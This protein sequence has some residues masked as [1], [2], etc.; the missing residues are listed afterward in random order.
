MMPQMGMMPGAADTT[1]AGTPGSA[2]PM[3]MPNFMPMPMI[4]PN[5]ASGPGAQGTQKKDQ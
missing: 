4:Y 2:Y 3:A 5:G 1:G